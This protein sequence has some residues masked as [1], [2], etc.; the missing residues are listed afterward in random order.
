MTDTHNLDQK[1]AHS[2]EA[3]RTP[4]RLPY[5]SPSLKCDRLTLVTRGGSFGEDDSG[6]TTTEKAPGGAT[7]AMPESEYPGT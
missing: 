4:L 7:S 1:P 3:P 2:G 5:Q 6:A